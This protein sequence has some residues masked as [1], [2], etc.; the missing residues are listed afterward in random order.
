MQDFLELDDDLGAAS[1]PCEVAEKQ[2]A[3]EVENGD[4]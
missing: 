3:F 2:N 1:T 4:V